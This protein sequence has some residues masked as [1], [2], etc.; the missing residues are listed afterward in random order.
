M[1]K[2]KTLALTQIYDISSGKEYM[3]EISIILIE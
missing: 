2:V 3:L 1:T